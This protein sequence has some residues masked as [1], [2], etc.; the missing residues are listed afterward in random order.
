[1]ASTCG[2]DWSTSEP[3]LNSVPF[4]DVWLDV[5][6]DIMHTLDMGVV[7]DFF[8]LLTAKA[9]PAVKNRPNI[10]KKA[11]PE[12]LKLIN[13]AI[14]NLQV[15][16]D[17]GRKPRSLDHMAT[18]K[19]IIFKTKNH[20]SAFF[21][22]SWR[23]LIISSFDYLSPIAEEWRSLLQTYSRAAFL[24]IS[25]KHPHWYFA[26]LSLAQASDAIR[27]TPC[28]LDSIQLAEHHIAEFHEAMHESEFQL[29]S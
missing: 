12:E 10:F 11:T 7:G 6:I 24:Q 26:L 18:Y 13:E 4:F 29:S 16:K 5:L 21:C 27:T 28:T 22:P 14:A 8:K 1:M 15:N 23:I 17:H 25:S 3:P 2:I 20:T 9:R 19:G